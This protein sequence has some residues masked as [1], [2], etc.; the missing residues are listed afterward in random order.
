M[1]AALTASG[2]VLSGPVSLW[3]VNATHPQP[4]WRGAATFVANY[5]PLQ[6][7]PF[8]LGFALVGGIVTLLASLALL[9][10]PA[11][12][13]RAWLA[14]TLGGAF[15]ALVFLN[16]TVQTTFVP[17][18]VHGYVPA[19][20]P[21]LAAFTMSNPSSLGWSIEM[22]AYAVAGVATWLASPVFSGGA[23]ERAT[24]FL[25]A[26]NG[27]A[28]IGSAL[29]TAFVPGWSLTVLG[30]VAFGVWNLLVV[31]MALA[32]WA[33]FRRRHTNGA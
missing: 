30:L 9:A 12:R 14:L 8:F 21:V 2:A 16:Y 28:G 33:A 5:H 32:A 4:A 27:P 25:F 24:A 11:E 26:L 17:L 29:A 10:G 22:W 20:A 19:D 15:A 1:G 31:V 7:L 3:L 13:P 18:L 23:L 6:T